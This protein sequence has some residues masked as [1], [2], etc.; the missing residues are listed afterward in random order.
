MGFSKLR[1]LSLLSILAVLL[2]TAAPVWSDH[3][4]LRNQVRQFHAFLQEHPKVATELRQ[5]PSL[6]NS[7]KYLNKH[8]DLEKFFKRHPSVKREVVNHPKRVFGKYYREDHA[9]W[10]HRN[11]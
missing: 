9:R 7:K 3:D 4:H 1:S 6:A 11:R 10:R 8:N 2:A 5:N